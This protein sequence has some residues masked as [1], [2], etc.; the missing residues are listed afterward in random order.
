[1]YDF[2]KQNALAIKDG[3]QLSHHHHYTV[4]VPF[5]FYTEF[6]EL[7][8]M[9]LIPSVIMVDF[10]KLKQNLFNTI[11]HQHH[12]S[13]CSHFIASLP[14]PAVSLLSLL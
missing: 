4:H 12:Q 11:A 13:F 14:S 8:V 10:F 3:V 2:W 7:S 1:M 5:A 9:E 6:P